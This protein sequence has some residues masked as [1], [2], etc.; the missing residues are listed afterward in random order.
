MKENVNLIKEIND[1]KREKKILKDDV[2]KKQTL[3]ASNLVK[4]K[5]VSGFQTENY[6]DVITIQREEVK[7]MQDKIK[8]ISQK[9]QVLKQKRPPSSGSKP[10][11]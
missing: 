4:K 7:E 8:E 6:E 2:A 1:L 3:A 9:I 10:S 5:N 11:F